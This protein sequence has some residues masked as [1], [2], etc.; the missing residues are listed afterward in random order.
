MGSTN[1]NP[2]VNKAYRVTVVQPDFTISVVNPASPTVARLT[3][4]NGNR[5]RTSSRDLNVSVTP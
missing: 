2:N 5:V 3:M 4:P 1:Q